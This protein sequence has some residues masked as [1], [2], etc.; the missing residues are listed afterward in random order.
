MPISLAWQPLRNR[1][2]TKA[3]KKKGNITNK[4]PLDIF[5]VGWGER[6]GIVGKG[7]G[8]ANTVIVSSPNKDGKE[9]YFSS[10]D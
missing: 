3:K 1:R 8:Q 10:L 7:G 6:L 9:T 5:F 4:D 2:H